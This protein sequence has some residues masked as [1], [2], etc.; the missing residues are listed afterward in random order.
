MDKN[1]EAFF[2]AVKFMWGWFVMMPMFLIGVS[3][4]VFAMYTYFTKEKE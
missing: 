1:D 3:L 4:L 2:E